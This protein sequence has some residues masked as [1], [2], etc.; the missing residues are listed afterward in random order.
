MLAPTC[1]GY[2]LSVPQGQPEADP[3]RARTKNCQFHFDSN[4]IGANHKD[5]WISVKA[6]SAA[7]RNDINVS[8]L[9]HSVCTIA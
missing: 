3:G 2:V 7:Q 8:L 1:V 4:E 5:A 9:S 6:S